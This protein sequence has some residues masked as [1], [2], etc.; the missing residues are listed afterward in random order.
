MN[1]KTYTNEEMG[2]SFNYPTIGVFVIHLH[3]VT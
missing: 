2:L 3:Y 1:W